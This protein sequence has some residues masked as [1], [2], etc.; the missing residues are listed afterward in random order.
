[1]GMM[2][3]MI[4]MVMLPAI[5]GMLVNELS[6]GWG[7]TTLSPVIAPAARILNIIIIAANSSQ[8][9]DDVR[10]MNPQLFGMAFFILCYASFGFVLGFILAKL[11]K[12]NR[13]KTISTVFCTGLR[14]I[15]VGCVIAAR[16][17]NGSVVFPVMMGT[18]FQ[19]V[20]AGI[21]G[22]I[23]LR[24]IDNDTPQLKN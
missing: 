10:H 15:S 18:L 24:L 6:H 17:F 2:T 1:M 19:Q 11:R 7:R 20:L 12:L 23:V 9:A 5:A 8:M 16:F 4:F 22:P 21:F 3:N 13:A 14:N